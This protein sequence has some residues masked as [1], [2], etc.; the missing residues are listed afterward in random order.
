M[1][2]LIK[3][4]ACH[5]RNCARWWGAMPHALNLMG[6]RASTAPP[7]FPTISITSSMYNFIIS[8]SMII[9]IYSP[10]HSCFHTKYKY[11]NE[12]FIWIHILGGLLKYFASMQINSNLTV[13]E[14][15]SSTY[16][17]THICILYQFI[18][19]IL[20]LYITIYD[21]INILSTSLHFTL[22]SLLNIINYS[23][24]VWIHFFHLGGPFE[25]FCQHADK[26]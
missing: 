5:S 1:W 6:A 8:L 15:T 18:L 21:C 20:T 2:Y 16:M 7:S 12:L 13:S 24:A 9:S 4:W 10:L 23:F 11:C 22:V 19:L 3:R 17:H 25:I 14:N 26:Q